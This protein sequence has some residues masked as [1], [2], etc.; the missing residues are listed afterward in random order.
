LPIHPPLGNYHIDY[1]I[2]YIFNCATLSSM[3][4]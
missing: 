1:T 2:I 4:C 3:G